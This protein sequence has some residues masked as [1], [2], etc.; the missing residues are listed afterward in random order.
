MALIPAPFGLGSSKHV[1]G[2]LVSVFA[3]QDPAPTNSEPLV[4]ATHAGKA[5]LPF[6]YLPPAGRYLLDAYAMRKL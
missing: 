6:S 5:T 2:D 3:H 4:G 1:K